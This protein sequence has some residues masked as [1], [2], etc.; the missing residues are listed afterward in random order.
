MF[1]LWWQEIG[2]G[3]R[4][5][6]S[7]LP[8]AAQAIRIVIRLLLAVQLRPFSP[9]GRRGIGT[10]P[11]GPRPATPPSRG[12]ARGRPSACLRCWAG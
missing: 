2:D 10:A 7:D 8:S 9:Y 5:D 6:F 3:L 4:E 12:D 1:G 11:S